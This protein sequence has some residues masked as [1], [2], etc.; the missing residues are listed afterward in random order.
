VDRAARTPARPP[1][2]PARSAAA[3]FA[4]LD[5]SY[6]AVGSL[7]VADRAARRGTRVGS[8]LYY[9]RLESELGHLLAARLGVAAAL[10]AALWEG[11]CA[12]R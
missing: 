5:D 12:T 1:I 10:T 4:T 7:L 9:R 3:L 2:P 11:A 8:A 6:A